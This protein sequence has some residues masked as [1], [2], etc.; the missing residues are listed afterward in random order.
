MTSA[1]ASPEQEQQ[2]EKQEQL[3]EQ[4]EEAA[5]FAVAAAPAA[6]AAVAAPESV[7]TMTVPTTQQSD[8]PY[9]KMTSTNQEESFSSKGDRQQVDKPGPGQE[10]A[11]DESSAAA[12]EK[13]TEEALPETVPETRPEALPEALLEARPEALPETEP[14]SVPGTLADDAV[15]SGGGRQVLERVMVSLCCVVFC[16]GFVADIATGRGRLLIFDFVLYEV[17]Y[18]AHTSRR[19]N[20]YLLYHVLFRYRYKE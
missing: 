7:D 12:T 1:A 5:A 8:E 20:V 16:F 18:L 19:L 14:E 6:A 15:A 3:H 9:P 10:Q 13:E 11:E 4:E 2:Q 17:S